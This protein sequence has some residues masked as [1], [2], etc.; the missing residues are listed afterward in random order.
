MTPFSDAIRVLMG[1]RYSEVREIFEK[2]GMDLVDKR[3]SWQQLMLRNLRIIKATDRRE[4][5]VKAVNEH[6]QTS[7]T[8]QSDPT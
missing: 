8:E 4:E 7:P 5:F 1:M 3:I 6:I 2:M